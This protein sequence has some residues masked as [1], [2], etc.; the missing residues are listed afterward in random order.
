MTDIV[1][2]GYGFCIPDNPHDSVSVKLPADERLYMITRTT[3]LPESLFSNFV[4]RFRRREGRLKL[5]LG[6]KMFLEAL[7]EKIWK[8]GFVRKSSA[9]GKEAIIYR[10]S[11]FDVLVRSF[12]YVLGKMKELVAAA[13]I[14]GKRILREKY[15]QSRKKRKLD[16]AYL[17]WY[18]DQEMTVWLMDHF[19]VLN[20][21]TIDVEI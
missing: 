17:H 5:L 13:E 3:P 9:A 4:S 21:W 8:L 14:K 15:A 12:G 16:P 18:G 1:L 19:K 6:Y 10:E 2:L 11:Q 20:S 7:N